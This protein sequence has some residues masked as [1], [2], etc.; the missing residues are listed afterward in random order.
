ILFQDDLVLKH[1]EGYGDSAGKLYFK[2]MGKRMDPDKMYIRI[3]G[4]KYVRYTPEF[5]EWSSWK[6]RRLLF[7]AKSLMET[8]RKENP[9]IRFALNLMYESVVNPSQALAWLSQDLRGAVKV[10]FDYY[11]IMAYHRQMATELNKGHKEVLALIEEMAEE[12]Q[13]RVGLSASVLMKIQTVDWETGEE[14]SGREVAYLIN[15]LKRRGVSIAVFPYR[16]LLPF[17]ELALVNESMKE[18]SGGR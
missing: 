16:R 10:G 14:L 9:G 2:E 15:T 11:S 4:E 7:V 8:A 18:T 5:W 12:A 17:D 3:E 6:N 1:T 13:R